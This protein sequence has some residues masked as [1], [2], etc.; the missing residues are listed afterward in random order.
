MR[1]MASASSRQ[2]L[3]LKPI[4][5]TVTR[6]WASISISSSSRAIGFS[7]PVANADFYG[8][9]VCDLLVDD[10]HVALLKL[11]DDSVVRVLLGDAADELFAKLTK[12]RFGQATA[13]H[14][15]L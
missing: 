1:T 3:P 8:L 11:R 7:L 10:G 6:P 2:R 9:I 14:T 15:E 12:L 13:F 4:V 5:C